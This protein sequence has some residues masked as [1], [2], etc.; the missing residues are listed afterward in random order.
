M[1]VLRMDKEI[2]TP[3]RGGAMD[4]VVETRRLPRRVKFAIGGGVLVLLIALFVA[5]SPSGN[6]QTIP[7]DRVT[8]STVS[9]GIFEDFLPLRARVTPLLSVYLD[10][11]EGGRVEKVL[12]E[13]GASVS[14]G[15]MLAILS[16][17]ELQL[18]VLAR[19][20]EVT[21]QLNAMRSQE[22]ALSQNRLA[23]ERNLLEAGLALDKAERQYKR[24]GALAPEGFIAG[25]TFADTKADYGYQQTRLAAY[26]RTQATD[27][28]LQTSQLA[29]LRRAAVSMQSGLALAREN[30]EALNLRAPV[31]G[32]LSAFSIQVGQSMGRGERIGQIDSPGR[33]KLIAEVDEYYLARVQPGQTASVD[34]NGKSYRLRVGKIYPTVKNGSFEVDLQFVGQEPDQVQRGQTLQP[35]LT[36]GDPAPAKLIPNGAF[37]NDTGGNWVFVV[38][39]DGRKAIKRPVRLGRRNADFIEVLDGLDLGEK[40]L[41]SPYSG[42]VDKERLELEGAAK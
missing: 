33:N 30:L 15:Q 18:S 19:Q 26:K 16:N 17:A 2:P 28:R 37:Y 42:F 11:I 34:W 20:T 12:V 25:K 4:R 1:S 6:S 38:T 13:D 14:K 5:F 24:E 23:N 31:A 35:K 10:S 22:L 29:E 3:P 7:A 9:R 8:V 36:L 32:T 21:Q 27:E 40:V 41:T 39:P